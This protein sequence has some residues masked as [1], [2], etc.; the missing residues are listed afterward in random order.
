MKKQL[1]ACGKRYD[2]IQR[3]GKDGNWTLSEEG[4]PTAL[5]FVGSHEDLEAYVTR[6]IGS[7]T[8]LP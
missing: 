3:D 6:E 8:W 1:D 4:S 5:I 7:P 2:V